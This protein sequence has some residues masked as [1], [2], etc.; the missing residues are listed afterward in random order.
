MEYHEGFNLEHSISHIMHEL[1]DLF[2]LTILFAKYN[3]LASF[4]LHFLSW[5]Y[6]GIHA[7]KIFQWSKSIVSREKRCGGCLKVTNWGWLC[8]SQKWGSFHRE[9][10]LS[11]CNML[12]CE[13]LLQVLLDIYS[14]RSYWIP[15]FTILLLFYVFEVGKAKSATQ[16]VLMELTLNGLFQKKKNLG[17]LPARKFHILNT[18]LLPSSASVFSFFPLWCLYCNFWL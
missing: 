17:T 9:G 18:R 3:I 11:L 10:R 12:Y 5:K 1:T 8:K 14:K 13:T 16:N 2:C 7:N 4:I 15:L 6:W